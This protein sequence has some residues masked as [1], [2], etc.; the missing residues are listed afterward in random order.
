MKSVMF[1]SL[2]TIIVILFLYKIN[3]FGSNE[4]QPAVGCG[5]PQ[6]CYEK[7]LITLKETKEY[8][9]NERAEIEKSVVPIGTVV[10]FAGPKSELDKLKSEGWMECAGQSL[11]RNKYPTLYGIIGTTYG[12]GDSP[13]SAFRLPD[14]RG[15]FLR[16]VDGERGVDTGPRSGGGQNGIGSTEG[17]MF[18]SHNHGVTGNGGAGDGGNN[19]FIFYGGNP[20]VNGSTFHKSTFTGG[21]E[22]RPKNM[23]VY[24]IIRT[25]TA[26]P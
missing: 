25:G 4:F 17:D 12:S 15:Y 5:T 3:E 1:T 2:M 8:W 24:Y 10:A 13:N 11:D 16:A 23:S 9:E 7:A 22:T 19:N 14:Y 6:Q 18:G 21:S 20:V 26:T